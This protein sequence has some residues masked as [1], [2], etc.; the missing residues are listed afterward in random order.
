MYRSVCFFRIVSVAEMEAAIGGSNKNREI[1]AACTLFL[2]DARI[3]N[4]K[5]FWP[6]RGV[7]LKAGA[8]KFPD[9]AWGSDPYSF[10]F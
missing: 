1:Q 7:R 3:K 6:R 8:A 4:R 5:L 2:I 9:T 10:R